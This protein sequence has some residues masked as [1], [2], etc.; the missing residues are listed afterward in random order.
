MR[1]NSIN[2]TLR[3]SFSHGCACKSKHPWPTGKRGAV[4]SD[5]VVLVL[6]SLLLP[7]I[8]GMREK[9][10]DLTSGWEL[11][12][13]SHAVLTKKNAMKCVCQGH[14]GNESS[15]SIFN[16]PWYEKDQELSPL[17]LLQA[18]I[19]TLL[20]WNGFLVNW[21]VECFAPEWL[22]A[23]CMSLKMIDL[24]GCIKSLVKLES[25][26]IDNNVFRLHYKITVIVL[27]TFSLLVN[28]RQYF[29]GNCL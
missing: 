15:L 22:F 26:C 5:F 25:I 10:S 21:T 7:L 19:F 11:Y 18:D 1:H 3:F 8:W 6:L 29:G 27:I 23:V 17:F 20:V 24:F 9:E 13:V 28:S 16:Q 12:I 4:C 2:K 14:D